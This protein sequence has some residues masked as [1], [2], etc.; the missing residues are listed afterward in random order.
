MTGKQFEVQALISLHLNTDFRLT[1][2]E[3]E[4]KKDTEIMCAF[5]T[6]S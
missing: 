4:G 1:Y 6:F 3:T 5:H 2:M